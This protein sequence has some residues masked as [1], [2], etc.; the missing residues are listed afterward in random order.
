[1]TVKELKESL[2]KYSDNLDVRIMNICIEDDES[3]PTFELKEISSAKEQ[4]EFNKNTDMDFVWLVIKD[5]EYI[6]EEF[7]IE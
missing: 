6:K 2:S 4:E 7:I 5:T 3:C 1:M